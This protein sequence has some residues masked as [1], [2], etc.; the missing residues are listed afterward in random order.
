[1]KKEN[2]LKDGTYLVCNNQ[3]DFIQT[4]VKIKNKKVYSGDYKY[5]QLDFFEKNKILKKI[6]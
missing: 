4:E 6:A 3:A 1:M 2:Y 5:N